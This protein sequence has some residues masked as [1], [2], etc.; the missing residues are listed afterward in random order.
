MKKGFILLLVAACIVLSGCRERIPYAKSKAGS[1]DPE[2]HG[3]RGTL[4]EAG[5]TTLQA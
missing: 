5:G 3:T 2:Y 4:W 1:Q